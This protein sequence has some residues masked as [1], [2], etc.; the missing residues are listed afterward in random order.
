MLGE[1]EADIWHYL[2]VGKIGVLGHNGEAV[3]EALHEAVMVFETKRLLNHDAEV[4]SGK[5]EALG[6]ELAGASMTTRF[7][8]K[9]YWQVR[10]ESGM[11]C[12]CWRGSLGMR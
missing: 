7:T 6:C 12:H 3:R 11:L 10:W 2:Y 8:P 5:F 4:V 1:C 9:R